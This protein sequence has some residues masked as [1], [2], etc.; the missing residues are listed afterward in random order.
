MKKEEY[1]KKSMLKYR[2]SDVVEMIAEELK[3]DSIE[4]MNM[5]YNSEV[6]EKLTDFET[7]LYSESSAYVFDLYR[8][9]L[10]FGKMVQLEI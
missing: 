8:D 9:E 10:K 6:F 2:I 4:A 7:G 3:V 5:F 1:I